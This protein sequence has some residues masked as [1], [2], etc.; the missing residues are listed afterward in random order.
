MYSS[1]AQHLT[2]QAALLV[3]QESQ[4]ITSYHVLH[5]TQPP[6]N[7]SSSILASPST[8]AHYIPP[9]SLLSLSP[10][11]NQS[12]ATSSSSSVL[13][14]SLCT[15]SVSRM[16][17]DCPSTSDP[18]HPHTGR[19]KCTECGSYSQA[20]H[21]LHQLHRVCL[22]NTHRAHEQE[23]QRCH[24]RNRERLYAKSQIQFCCNSSSSAVQNSSPYVVRSQSCPSLVQMQSFIGTSRRRE[25][26]SR[27]TL[28]KHDVETDVG[29]VNGGESKEAK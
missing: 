17:F 8:R 10:V 14:Q 23:K 24:S 16:S 28:L 29:V 21:T 2:R 1:A 3:F 27:L 11:V 20:Q 5:F 13:S 15:S 6:A 22:L 12:D 7:C 18:Y 4:H 25:D 19:D 26:E 9:Q